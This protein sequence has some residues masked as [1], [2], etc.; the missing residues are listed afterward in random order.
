[1]CPGEKVGK[2]WK[3]ILQRPIADMMPG[4]LAPTRRDLDCV[5]NI[6]WIWLELE[7][8]HWN[9]FTIA[10]PHDIVNGNVL[11]NSDNERHFRFDSFFDSC[12]SLRRC[13]VDARRI[14]LQLFHCFP[15]RAHDRQTQVHLP[16]FLWVG[17]ADHICPP[18]DRFLRV[19]CGLPTRKALEDDASVR[20]N[21]EVLDR[22]VVATASRSR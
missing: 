11:G 14:W 19:G 15:N 21:L 5:F 22:V 8:R 4:A 3:P 9:I 18:S 13:D 20:S 10:Y 7:D 2:G 16:I 1:M 17:T 6:E 12:S